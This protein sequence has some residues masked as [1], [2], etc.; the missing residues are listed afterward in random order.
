MDLQIYK[1]QN[2][3]KT[4]A[5][6]TIIWDIPFEIISGVECKKK[7]KYLPRSMGKRDEKKLLYKLI[8]P[9][10]AEDLKEYVSLLIGLYKDHVSVSCVFIY[11]L[12]IVSLYLART[13]PLVIR[14]SQ[15][16]V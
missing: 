12:L 8:S 16:N 4:T 1:M 10:L 5:K 14:F 7:N 2:I 11:F 13:Q 6:S 15:N 3:S 9:P